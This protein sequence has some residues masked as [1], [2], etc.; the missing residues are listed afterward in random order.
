MQINQQMGVLHPRKY[1][2]K[3]EKLD[4]ASMTTKLDDQKGKK[5]STPFYMSKAHLF[6]LLNIGDM[7][8]QYGAMRNCWEDE[9]ERYIQNVKREISTMK[10]NE[11]YLKTILTKILRIDVSASFNKDNPFSNEKNIPR[12]V[13]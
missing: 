4:D 8:E 9:N 2:R 5:K 10:H 11:K 3:E 6:S 13:M 7:I 1:A 12:P